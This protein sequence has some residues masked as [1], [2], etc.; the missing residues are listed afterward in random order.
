MT[1]ESVQDI[2]TKT[3]TYLTETLLPFWI[4]RSVDDECGGFL[5]YFDRNGQVTGETDKAELFSYINPWNNRQRD[6]SIIEK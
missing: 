5:T 4:K 3:K 1:V 6:I 2:L